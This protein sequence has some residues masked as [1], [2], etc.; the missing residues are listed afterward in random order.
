MTQLEPEL[1][2]LVHRIEGRFGIQI[3]P[4]EIGKLHTPALL[5]DYLGQRLHAVCG[6]RCASRRAFFRLRQM[7]NAQF[8]VPRSAIRPC[9]AVASVLPRSRRRSQW[10]LLRHRMNVQ[11][12]PELW[13][14]PWLERV[15]W[16]GGILIGF[17]LLLGSVAAGAHPGGALLGAF[18]MAALSGWILSVALRSWEVALPP[19]YS[20]L[21]DLALAWV[22]SSAP[23]AEG[24][25]TQWTQE[26]IAAVVRD[27][28]ARHHNVVMWQPEARFRED[29]GFE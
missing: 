8:R 15:V 25:G 5:I 22:A 16:Y 9:T 3:P 2:E 23:P 28:L 21:G 29:L 12:W 10:T 20:T 13:P 11:D 27:L 1:V 24:T 19:G 6:H 14:E 26:E 4:A 7:L 17:A 18:L